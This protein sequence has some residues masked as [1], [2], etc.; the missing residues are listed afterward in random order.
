MNLYC[1]G[2]YQKDAENV[3]T[4]IDSI[5]VREKKDGF[6]DLTTDDRVLAVNRIEPVR[7]GLRFILRSDIS[8]HHLVSKHQAITYLG[9]NHVAIQKLNRGDEKGEMF[10]GFEKIKAR[11]RQLFE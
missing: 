11:A 7:E 5:I 8:S 9:D 2:Y 10:R 1:V 3:A 4:L 6:Y